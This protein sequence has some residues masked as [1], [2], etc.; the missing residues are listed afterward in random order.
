MEY[1]EGG[2][3][4]PVNPAHY[5]PID[6]RHGTVCQFPTKVRNPEEKF[7][8]HS[9]LPEMES[10]QNLHLH[11]GSVCQFP[12]KVL[13]TG[14]KFTEDSHIK[15]IDKLSNL[16]LHQGSVCQFPQKV[17]NPEE[18]LPDHSH[19]HEVDQLEKL[20]LHQG[21]VCQFPT[22]IRNPED[23]YPDHPHLHEV[24]DNKH[25]HLK[26]G[27][28]CQFPSNLSSTRPYDYFHPPDEPMR[29]TLPIAQAH[30]PDHCLPSQAR[31]QQAYITH[32]SHG[33]SKLVVSSLDNEGNQRSQ[34]Q[35]PAH[36]WPPVG[37]NNMPR[38]TFHPEGQ[39]HTSWRACDNFKIE[40]MS[41][42]FAT[43]IDQEDP[44]HLCGRLRDLLFIEVSKN[45][46]L[47]DQR[48]PML[49][50]QLKET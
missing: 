16:H 10:L 4:I 41:N 3:E 29:E 38:K 32:P 31:R 17:R 20:H 13:K 1:V 26:Q 37:H 35:S 25:L 34:G 40:F 6:L 9:H 2:Q 48:E 27:S 23:K 15:E 28:V 18:K 45:C 8:D 44:S 47:M 39:S 42:F 12:Q 14:T 49:G 21:S 5:R 11:Q 50:I 36:Q 33:T 7:P 19:L 24:E 46:L 30:H 43:L 22:K